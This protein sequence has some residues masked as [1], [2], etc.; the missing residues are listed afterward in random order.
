MHRPGSQ[1]S[2]CGSRK[3]L[4]KALP[5]LGLGFPIYGKK[6]SRISRLC[7][8]FAGTPFPE[9]RWLGFCP[10]LRKQKFKSLAFYPSAK[11]VA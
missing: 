3:L 9:L 1:D 6:G 2:L 8:L 4:G 7:L 5:P 11:G 10:A